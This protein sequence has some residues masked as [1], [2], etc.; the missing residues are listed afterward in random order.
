[1]KC[2]LI[3][4]AVLVAVLA[5]ANAQANPA[6]VAE[7]CRMEDEACLKD[8]MCRDLLLCVEKCVKLLPDDKTPQKF[9][10]Q[11][12]TNK[13]V[14]SFA[15]PAYV[16]LMTCLVENM[17]LEL[18][19][20]PNPCRGNNITISK[21][22]PV[23]ALAGTWWSVRGYNPVYDC[24]PCQ[25]NTFTAETAT[26]VKYEAK[27]DVYKVDGTRKL[28]ESMAT[29]MIT[30]DYKAGYKMNFNIAGMPSDETWWVVDAVE[31]EGETY[32]LAYYCAKSLEWYSDGA[33]VFSR[34][35]MLST[36]AE[37]AINSAFKAALG[38]D[39]D[40]YKFCKND[41]TRCEM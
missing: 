28:E 4:L 2:V 35:K 6:C 38:M 29:L 33:I 22:V 31:S 36:T 8:E 13:C 9:M 17:C 27:F 15:S 21:A 5:T 24:Y 19:P 37:P 23:T 34:T 32:V 40:L 16:E 18:P 41:N 14:F 39:F 12:C 1:M 20:L 30:P 25:M 10:V 7:H 3:P 11:N 26:T